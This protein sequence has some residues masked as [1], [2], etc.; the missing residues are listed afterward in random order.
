MKVALIGSGKTGSKVLEAHSSTTVFNRSNI[1]TTQ[2]LAGHDVI[3]S[4][5]PGDA[6][7]E[8]IPTLIE[9]GIPVV[10]GSTGFKWPSTIDTDLKNNN[11]AWIH[12]TNFSLGMNLVHQMIG[13]LSKAKSLFLDAEF[14]IHE[15]HHTKKLDAPSGTALSWQDW[16]GSKCEI[17]SER[18]GDVIG[19][20]EL[21]LNT[22]NETIFLK[23]EA[24]DRGIFAAGA[25]WAAKHIT[26]KNKVSSGLNA[27]ADV[28]LKELK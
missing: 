3:I 7:L 2:S 23:H 1:P 28:I 22:K 11:V 25:L 16:V 20:H 21:S 13:I 26:T 9:T 14:N 4:F 10:T 8:L 17:T 24:K 6:F 5:L 27:F 12:A 19:I 15:V 18:T